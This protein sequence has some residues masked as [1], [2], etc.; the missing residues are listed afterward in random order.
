[1]DSQLFFI[2][3]QIIKG[4]IQ[5]KDYTFDLE[6]KAVNFTDA[7]IT[8]IEKA[9]SI[10]NLYDL[11][12]QA[13]YHY[14]IQS[15]RAEVIFRRDVDY[16]IREG[17]IELIDAF[18]GRIL[19]GRSLS[20]GLHQAIEAKEGLE[21]TD[22]NRT[23]AT[24]TIQ[25]YFRMYPILSGM[26][27]TAKTEEKEFQKVYG[28]NVIQIPTN[29]P[30]IR[31][32][33]ED[34][35]FEKASHKYKAL[36]DEVVRRHQTGQPILI[37]TT[38]IEQSET[39]E[40]YLDKAGLSFQLLNAKSAEKEAQLIAVAGQKNQITIA[41]NM[42]GRGTDILL[43]EGVAELGGL[44]VMGTERHESRRV[45]NQLKGRAG[46]Q[47]DPGSSQ[48]FIS[49]EDELIQRF[50]PDLLEKF[51][52]GLKADETGIVQNKN[53]HEFVD[54]V[55]S[56]CE[57]SNFSTREYTLKLDDVVNEQRNV[58]Y[59]L[60]NRVLDAEDPFD[61]IKEMFT[62]LSSHYLESLTNEPGKLDEIT[63]KLQAVTLSEITGLQDAEEMDEYMDLFQFS[64]DETVKTIVDIHDLEPA[65]FLVFKGEVLNAIDQQWIQHLEAMTRL[66]EGIGLR[67]YSQEDP[68]RLYQKDGLDIFTYTYT[69]IEAEICQS[70]VNSVKQA[71]SGANLDSEILEIEIEEG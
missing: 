28:M 42:A 24:V 44:H 46:R 2:C 38:S 67:G 54:R 63:E 3:S 26:T 39:V 49:I 22:E 9:F 5:D 6:T 55:Q 50:A 18:T 35:V 51:K 68:I 47:G 12:H 1:L 53:V 14:L 45:D 31:V 64:I 16:I 40:D 41:T 25:N 60:R 56:I 23:Q 15:L 17:K 65:S 70:V 8:K 48:F 58:I 27:G 34:I 59:T 11:T 37:G 61:F 66:K 30:R 4:F 13:L 69:E 29:R 10:D 36:T 19:E 20:D 21:M 33:M 52:K 32:D 43:G 57:G 62:H 71:A 7:G